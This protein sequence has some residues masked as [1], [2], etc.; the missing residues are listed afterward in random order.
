MFSG[1]VRLDSAQKALLYSPDTFYEQPQ[2]AHKQQDPAAMLKWKAMITKRLE[3]NLCVYKKKQYSPKQIAIDEFTILCLAHGVDMLQDTIPI[4]LCDVGAAEVK[5]AEAK[6]AL[7][8]W[9]GRQD[10]GVED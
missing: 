7:L 5:D 8:H 10:P 4:G 2:L 1:C 3:C 6:L 9:D